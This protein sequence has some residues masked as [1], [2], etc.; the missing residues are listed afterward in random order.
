MLDN[1]DGLNGELRSKSAEVHGDYEIEDESVLHVVTTGDGGTELFHLLVGKASTRGNCFVR[2]EGRDDVHLV[3]GSL[4]SSFGVRDT[5]PTPPEGKR[6]ID[7]S[8]YQAERSDVDRIV[9]QGSDG[10]LILEKEFATPDAEGG[11]IDRSQ[12]TWKADAAGEF[13]KNKADGVVGA[14]C[15]LYAND[16]VEPGD[17]DQYGLGEDARSAELTFADGTATTVYF[18]RATGEDDK[19]V[20]FRVGEEGDPAEI[21]ASTVD[22]IFV[23]RSE[24]QPTEG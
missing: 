12:W 21:Y 17:L 7:L 24:L 3:T 14:L 22:R 1:L 23:A 15:N 20:Y 16:V 19:F 13:D 4:R 5:D 11:E 18:G 9:L 8:I 10:E 2:L 6:W